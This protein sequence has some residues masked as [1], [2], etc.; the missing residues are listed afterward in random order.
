MW[1]FIYWL[2]WLLLLGRMI[3]FVFCLLLFCIREKN[4]CWTRGICTHGTTVHRGIKVNKAGLCLCMHF[5]LLLF[6]QSIF[7]DF[8]DIF[9]FFVSIAYTHI[10]MIFVFYQV[11]SA[12]LFCHS[13]WIFF[14][15]AFF[16]TLTCTFVCSVCLLLNQ[17][18]MNQAC[19]LDYCVEELW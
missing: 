1:I 7:K 5:F 9:L 19:I 4:T 16:S 14:Y 11:L 12:F 10:Y 8:L 13:K 2:C 18:L 17:F 6:F 15:L 3:L